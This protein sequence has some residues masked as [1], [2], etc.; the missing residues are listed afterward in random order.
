MS[1][2]GRRERIIAVGID[3]EGRSS[4][5]SHPAFP[6]AARKTIANTVR[7]VLSRRRKLSLEGR[8]RGTTY[9]ERVESKTLFEQR[10]RKIAE[11]CPHPG[12]FTPLGS[13]GTRSPESLRSVLRAS[14][15]GGRR[16]SALKEDVACARLFPRSS[17]AL[18]P[19]PDRSGQIRVSRRG[20]RDERV[21]G[22]WSGLLADNRR[23]A[24][25][26]WRST[27]QRPCFDA[28]REPRG[29]KILLGGTVRRRVFAS[30]HRSEKPRM[31]GVGWATVQRHLGHGS[32]TTTLDAYAHLWPDSDDVTRRAL[33]AG[34]S[35][36][37][38]AAC[39]E[40]V[41]GE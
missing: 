29:W 27:T 1:A 33:D 3:G 15:K 16:D 36:V 25:V 38:S 24:P 40:P 4:L 21:V 6:N 34:L 35:A 31:G 2:S 23:S 9:R 41:V 22:H 17:E 14:P 8:F 30:D 26:R 13:T 39:P 19:V 20:I 5:I 11:A 32:A 37:V 7:Y 18:Q 10:C 12:A 28:G